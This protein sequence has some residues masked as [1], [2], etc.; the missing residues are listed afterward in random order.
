MKALGKTKIREGAVAGLRWEL[1]ESA[2]YFVFG[3][4]TD[5][6]NPNVTFL[7]VSYFKMIRNATEVGKDQK[8]NKDI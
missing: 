1:T 7:F 5:S 6:I 8:A 2:Q 3:S 4:H